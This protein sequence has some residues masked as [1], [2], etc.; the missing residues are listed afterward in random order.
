MKRILS[1]AFC[2]LLAACSGTQ[3]VKVA[4][5]GV[6]QFHNE[7][8]AGRYAQLYDQSAS[9]MK[10]ATKREDFI[11][12]VRG[13]HRK[14]G[15]FESGK[16]VGWNVN[17]TPTGQFVTLTYDSQYQRGPAQEQFVFRVSDD[18]AIL[19]GYRVNSTVFVTS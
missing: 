13:G 10:S 1:F 7:L 19:A 15:A 11:A 6:G 8:N 3:S 9:E 5:Q 16:Q 12:F 17:Y 2:L 14:L 4:E 18:R